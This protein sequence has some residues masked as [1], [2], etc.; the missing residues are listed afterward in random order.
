MSHMSEC[1]IILSYLHT[2]DN[3]TWRAALFVTNNYSLLL[4]RIGLS[5]LFCKSKSERET[6]YKLVNVMI[7]NYTDLQRQYPYPQAHC[8]LPPLV[9]VVG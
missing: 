2:I 7:E 5:V 8:R 4:H 9:E 3:V 1:T 6:T